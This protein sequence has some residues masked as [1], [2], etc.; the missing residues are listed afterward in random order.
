MDVLKIKGTVVDVN[1]PVKV[2]VFHFVI[3]LYVLN[4]LSKRLG[5]HT[6]KNRTL[7]VETELCHN[8]TSMVYVALHYIF[9]LNCLVQYFTRS[10]L[11]I[12]NVE[13]LETV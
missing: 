2:N 11:K 5:V 9:N 7:W 12:K 6:V 4:N 3:G 10:Q 1:G 8:F 13:N